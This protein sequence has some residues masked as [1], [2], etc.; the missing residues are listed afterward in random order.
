MKGLRL[1]LEVHG[2]GGWLVVFFC[3]SDEAVD[4]VPG[5]FELLRIEL[6]VLVPVEMPGRGRVE[7]E[8]LDAVVDVVERGVAREDDEVVLELARGEVLV[9][10]MEEPV[11][12]F[13]DVHEAVMRAVS[14]ESS[15]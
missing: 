14:W 6:R 10:E 9:A 12:L 4:L 7:L 15:Q 3:S 5:A 1:R 13:L 2:P 11:V 8:D